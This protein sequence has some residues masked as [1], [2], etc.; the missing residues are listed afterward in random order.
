MWYFKRI[1]SLFFI[2]CN[3]Y[4]NG[5]VCC[6]FFT[7]YLVKKLQT[8]KCLDGCQYRSINPQNIDYCIVFENAILAITSFKGSRNLHGNKISNAKYK[9]LE[10]NMLGK[11]TNRRTKTSNTCM[12][13]WT[14]FMRNAVVRRHKM[15]CGAPW[16]HNDSAMKRRVPPSKPSQYFSA[17]SFSFLSRS[18]AAR[19]L[20]PSSPGP[21]HSLAKGPERETEPQHKGGGHCHS[22]QSPAILKA[23]FQFRLSL[24]RPPL[25]SCTPSLLLTLCIIMPRPLRKD[26]DGSEWAGV[27][28]LQ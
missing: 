5:R 26:R 1:F 25:S 24:L 22:P 14:V 13:T 17:F 4:I 18:F 15:D 27:G 20:S 11:Y 8:Q 23:T 21:H 16:Q 12:T 6:K 7:S 10:S 28:H 9:K 19:F 2:C 3:K